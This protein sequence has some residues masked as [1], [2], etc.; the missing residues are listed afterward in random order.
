MKGDTN[1]VL[2]H[3]A[4]HGGWCW[5]HV[6]KNIRQHGFNVYTPTLTGLGERSHLISNKIT[7]NTFVNDVS[8]L[9]EWEQLENIVLVGHS[10]GGLA[11]IG[12][13]DKLPERIK[14]VVL[15]DAFLLNNNQSTM[16]SLPSTVVDKL[17]AIAKQ[18]DGLTIPAPS[19]SSL[20]ISDPEQ[21]RWVESLCTPHPISSYESKFYIKNKIGNG[22]PVTYIAV[23]PEYIPTSGARDYAK[24]RS[25]WN[26]ITIEAG[27]DAM[28]THP[29]LLAT[30]LIDLA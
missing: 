27:H 14:H 4:W 19:A 1:F 26:Y 7:L 12:V 20:G 6:A 24:S 16:E 21:A 30:L 5:K 18:H 22:L 15:L 25:D 9:I 13:A 28:V 2:V 17:R 23:E 10:F 11:A 29:E 3:G 8:G